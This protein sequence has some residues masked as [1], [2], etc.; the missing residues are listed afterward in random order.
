MTSFQTVDLNDSS[1]E[2]EKS[3][4]FANDS[5]ETLLQPRYESKWNDISNGGT[6]L[7]D[8]RFKNDF[9]VEYRIWS[10]Y[11]KAN[12]IPKNPL[13]LL[14]PSSSH[15]MSNSEWSLKSMS[16][17]DSAKLLNTSINCETQRLVDTSNRIL[18]DDSSNDEFE[19]DKNSLDNTRNCG[20]YQGIIYSSLSSVFFSLCAVIVKYLKVTNF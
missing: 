17:Q 2:N 14:L 16:D 20:L 10:N 3:K 19:D 18:F 12:V 4:S 8:P 1:Y 5:N 15:K 9:N 11:K 6:I 7:N 13:S